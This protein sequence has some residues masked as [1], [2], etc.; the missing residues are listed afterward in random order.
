MFQQL[1]RRHTVAAVRQQRALR[2][3]RLEGEAGTGLFGPYVTLPAGTYLARLRF[4]AGR[5]ASGR[6]RMDVTCSTGQHLLAERQVEAGM[7]GVA[8]TCLDLPFGAEREMAALEVRLFCEPGFRAA[9]EGVEI[10]V[11]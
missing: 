4:Q 9:I 11:G 5:P 2:Q 1:Q 3:I 8:G 7:I 6:A 10:L